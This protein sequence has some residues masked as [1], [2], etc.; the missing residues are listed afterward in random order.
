MLKTKSAKRDICI[1][2]CLVTCLREAKAV[3]KSEYVITVS[4]G[5]YLSKGPSLK[6]VRKSTLRRLKYGMKLDL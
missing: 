3:S 2:K 6:K 4:E 5:Q 1:Q